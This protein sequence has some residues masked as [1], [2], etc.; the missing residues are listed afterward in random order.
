MQGA[1]G[2]KSGEDNLVF[3]ACHVVKSKVFGSNA[4]AERGIYS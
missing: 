3:L 4:Q 1:G 2:L